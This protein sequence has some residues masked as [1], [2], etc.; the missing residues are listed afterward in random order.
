MRTT[1][2]QPP[3]SLLLVC[4]LAPVRQGIIPVCELRH[5]VAHSRAAAT[6]SSIKPGWEEGANDTGLLENDK[7][8][9]TLRHSPTRGLNEAA[10]GRITFVSVGHDEQIKSPRDSDT[11]GSVIGREAATGQPTEFDRNCISP[12]WMGILWLRFR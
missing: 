12:S 11:W 2:C 10:I 3:F 7:I 5:L 9:Q 4:V 8:T 6:V 1:A